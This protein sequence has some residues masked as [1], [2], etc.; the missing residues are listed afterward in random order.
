MGVWAC[1]CAGVGSGRVGVGV[2]V[3]LVVGSWRGVR[4]APHQSTCRGGV[5]TRLAVKP[6]GWM[7]G[8]WSMQQ[9]KRQ[10][11]DA[12]GDWR[13]RE[14]TGAGC[15]GLEVQYAGSAVTEA[16][17]LGRGWLSLRL[18][19]VA[20]Q[21]AHTQVFWGGRLSQS[22]VWTRRVGVPIFSFFPRSAERTRRQRRRRRDGLGG[23]FQQV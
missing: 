17:R 14:R 7:M 8:R 23:A 9:R 10:E 4:A 12:A 19:V 13:A 21:W 3:R 15:P 20:C 16:N 2:G 18:V 11:S 22:S 5:C 1:G 6:R